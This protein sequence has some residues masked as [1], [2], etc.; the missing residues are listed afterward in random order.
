MTSPTRPCL[1]VSMA[2]SAAFAACGNM[3]PAGYVPADTADT[4]ITYGGYFDTD[5]DTIMDVQEGEESDD[6]DRDGTPNYRDLDSDGDGIKDRV[7]AGDGDLLTL[8]VDTDGDGIPDFLDTDSDDDGV[9]DEVEHGFGSSPADTDGDGIYDFRDPDDDGDGILTEIESG[10]DGETDSDGDGTPDYL[11]TD[12]DDDGIAD[13]YE[14]GTSEFESDPVDTDSDGSPDYLDPDSDNDG[15]S[16]AVEGGG[17]GAPRDTDSD[18]RCDFQDT[19]SDGDGLADA[20]ESVVGADP[21]D[22]DT[23]G[24]GQLDGAEVAAGTDPLDP[25]STADSPFVEVP[26]R[27]AIDKS[28]GFDLSIHKADIA[29]L[30]DTSWAMT[31]TVND[32]SDEFASIAGDL[33]GVIADAAYG[34]AHH[35]DYHTSPM[36]RSGDNPFYL[37]QQIT[38]DI[39]LVQTQISSTT[40]HDGEDWTE[41]GH[42]AIYQGASGMGYDMECDGLFDDDDDVYPFIA[43]PDD[44]FGGTAGEWD[45]ADTPG[46]GTIGGFGFRDLALPIIVHATENPFRNGRTGSSVPGG[47]PQDATDEDAI[48]AMLDIGARYIGID[49][50]SWYHA[51]LP[52]MQSIAAGTDSYA[53]T[54]GD[55]ATDDLLAFEL[56][57]AS[58]SELRDTIV[59]AITELTD[60]I[61]VDRV[62]LQIEGDDHG[63][64]TGVEPAYYADVESPLVGRTLPFTLFFRGIVAA[65][66]EDQEFILTLNV[67]GDGTLLLDSKDIAVIVPGSLY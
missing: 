35:E 15:F 26:E 60:A 42:E 65:T 59:G 45:V 5:G 6:A 23:D 58:S 14:A 66:T 57:S 36:G 25:T 4:A 27:S 53:D 3:N 19:D 46:G 38:T 41:A 30:F 18:G 9:K 39:H 48:G 31:G 32:M 62:E 33:E 10:R 34:Y 28:F 21:F 51:A 40:I 17:T 44:P 12:S 52:Y 43:S 8:P 11:D 47:C 2:F 16:D 29:F 1:V 56:S 20:D 49:P 13:V 61:S 54:D 24:D 22:A 50:G 63:F 55:G 7:E 67:I 37:E 64:V